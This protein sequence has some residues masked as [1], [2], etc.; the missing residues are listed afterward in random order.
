MHDLSYFLQLYLC[1]ITQPRN[2]QQNILKQEKKK[3]VT[4]LCFHNWLF[5][6]WDE[7]FISFFLSFLDC[8]CL[9][10]LKLPIKRS[11][12]GRAGQKG[13]KKISKS[14]VKC[15]LTEQ[16]VRTTLPLSL[17]LAFVSSVFLSRSIHHLPILYQSA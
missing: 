3:K 14:A 9:L 5:L 11:S 10:C 15:F 13:T 16:R 1:K 8:I 6:W 12:T 7:S 4:F 2:Q 17:L